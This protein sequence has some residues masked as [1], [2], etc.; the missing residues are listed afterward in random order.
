MALNNK[1]MKNKNN[2]FPNPEKNFKSFLS[3]EE[4]KITEENVQKIGMG[5]IVAAMALSGLMKPD[6]TFGKTC[7]HS[8][9][10]SHASH[11]SHGSHG[12]H[13]AW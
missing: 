6:E 1:N 5:L 10:G 8:S 11:G 4:G 9:H 12:S 2:K 13:T 3:E 7:S